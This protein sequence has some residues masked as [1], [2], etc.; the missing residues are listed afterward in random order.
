MSQLL[1][2][3]FSISKIRM[4]AAWMTMRSARMICSAFQP[5]GWTRLVELADRVV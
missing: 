5:E 2:R 1:D 4:A 3:Q